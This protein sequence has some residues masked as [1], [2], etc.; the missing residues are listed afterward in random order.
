MNKL[1][2][3]VATA[4]LALTTATYADNT[5]NN[6]ADPSVSANENATVLADASSNK[7]EMMGNTDTAK[8][9]D[10]MNT[11]KKEMTKKH[12]KHKKH[13]HKTCHSHS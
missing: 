8:P 6:P 5:M 13:H 3:L 12:K 4:S 9:S 1:L 10:D 7:P 11:D 2:I